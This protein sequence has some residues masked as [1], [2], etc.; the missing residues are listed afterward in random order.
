MSKNDRIRENQAQAD[1]KK[2]VS[3][4]HQAR[5][6]LQAR[7]TELSLA[8]M[9]LGVVRL[10]RDRLLRRYRELITALGLSVTNH[11]RWAFGQT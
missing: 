10:Q 1:L 4:L 3:L 5:A 6:D 9:E 11:A 8:R 2:A 7:T